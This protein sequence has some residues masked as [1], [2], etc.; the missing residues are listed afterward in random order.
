MNVV[1]LFPFQLP[2]AHRWVNHW[3]CDTWAMRHQTPATFPTSPPFGQYQIILLDGRG[4]IRPKLI[5][6]QATQ[7][8]H[9]QREQQW[10]FVRILAVVCISVNTCAK[11]TLRTFAQ[12]IRANSH[13]SVNWPSLLWQGLT[14]WTNYKSQEMSVKT[15]N[16]ISHGRK[17]LPKE[18]TDIGVQPNSSL[19]QHELGSKWKKYAW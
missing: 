9:L 8:R 14:R 10:I 15:E 16:C 6:L 17:K 4:R 11:T 7:K 1:H 12:T 5:N 13:V 19:T 2:W 3:D 18:K